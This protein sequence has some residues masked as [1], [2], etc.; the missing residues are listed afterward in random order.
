M[1]KKQFSIG[2]FDSGFGGL[3]VLKEIKKKLPQ[4]D[5]VYL[6]DTARTPYGTRSHET[7]YAYATQAVDFL[8][9]HNCELIIV[10]C[11]TASAEALRKIQQEYLPKAYPDKRV[12]GVIVPALEEA[13]VTTKNHR[14]GVI[15]TEGT[16]AS[17]AFIMELKKR[18]PV[19]KIFQKACPLLVPLVEAGEHRAPAAQLI[20]KKYLQ[21]FSGKNIDTL[22]LGCTHYGLLERQIKQVVGKKISLISEGPVVA[23]KLKEYLARHPEIETK[24]SKKK[25]IM[26]Y[27]TD[28]GDRFDRLGRFFFGRRLDSRKVVLESGK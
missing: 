9:A 13:A 24:L 3:A 15:A 7:I 1:T 16:V 22:I 4:Y 10:A 11:N 12:L 18:D 19:A 27:S 26:F 28:L 2:I 20:L 14:I 25:H 21:A 5:Y 6:G 8:F 23:R 17:K